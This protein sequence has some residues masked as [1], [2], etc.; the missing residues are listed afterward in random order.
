MD[1]HNARTSLQ[2]VILTHVCTL[3]LWLPLQ[4]STLSFCILHI[5]V[6][7]MPSYLFN[8]AFCAEHAG[9]PPPWLL[10]QLSAS[11]LHSIYNNGLHAFISIQL[12]ILCNPCVYSTSLI[13][14]TVVCIFFSMVYGG[15][16]R[17][18]FQ[19]HFCCPRKHF[20]ILPSMCTETIGVPIIK[21]VEH[22]NKFQ[23]RVKILCCADFL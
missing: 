20:V 2:F 12:C 10:P 6:G 4:L 11:S 3:P 14:T 22:R 15:P 13:T 9:T 17:E 1:H 18:K 16:F 23:V 21:F 8:Y 7:C 5:T 19:K